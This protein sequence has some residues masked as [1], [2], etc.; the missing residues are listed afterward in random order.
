MAD[1]PAPETPPA[2]DN[3][4]PKSARPWLPFAVVG[5][6]VGVIIIASLASGGDREPATPT[7]TTIEAARDYCSAGQVADGG[8]TLVVD[9]AGATSAS[10]AD[11]A[12]ELTCLLTWFDT[13]T[14]V[15]AQM[16][17]TR[18][19]DGMQNASWDGYSASWTYHPDAGLDITITSN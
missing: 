9:T 6:I 11:T 16:E 1:M 2:A 15:T 7:I 12:E 5:A 3:T 14:S 4:P 10:G 18:A 8:S 19:L 13:P 17:R